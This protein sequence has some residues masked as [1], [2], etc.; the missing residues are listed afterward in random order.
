MLLAGALPASAQSFSTSAHLFGSG[1]TF[2]FPDVSNSSSV[3]P[4][5]ATVN[6]SGTFNLSSDPANASSASIQGDATA[7]F[8]DLHLFLTATAVGNFAS[9][10]S[11][12]SASSKGGVT[13]TDR[14]RFDNTG[15][16]VGSDIS[17]RLELN[18]SASVHLSAGA[19]EPFGGGYAGISA[20]LSLQDSNGEVGSVSFSESNLQ[21]A[22]YQS[23]VAPA[24]FADNRFVTL[25]LKTGV[26]YLLSGIMDGEASASSFVSEASPSTVVS[27][28]TVDAGHTALFAILPQTPG[29]TFAASSGGNYQAVPE[30][31]E[32]GMLVGGVL[33]GGAGVRR[34]RKAGRGG[35]RLKGEKLKR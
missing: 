17:V 29:T 13:F 8:G 16:P 24:T 35:A 18:V 10:G 34:W 21:S 11:G 32:W 5:S 14:V 4:V 3:R 7:G 12:A 2:S 9:G 28:A 30:P 23:K 33:M 19:P 20:T 15:L 1:T 25:T 22:S 27:A 26:N 31:Q 6:H